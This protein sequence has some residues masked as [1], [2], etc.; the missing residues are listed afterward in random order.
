[1]TF[2]RLDQLD[3][4]PA[5]RLDVLHPS[6]VSLVSVGRRNTEPA[7]AQ[8]VEHGQGPA[9]DGRGVGVVLDQQIAAGAACHVV[10]R[11]Q[12]IWAVM[13][14]VDGVGEIERGVR[15]RQPR[16][17]VELGRDEAA[18]PGHDV[19]GHELRDLR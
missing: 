1:M 2:E 7:I 5:A 17:V 19:H 13:K 4:P 8:F 9:A 15:E 3:P 11:R 12:R 6:P 16:A 14:H 18:G 10:D